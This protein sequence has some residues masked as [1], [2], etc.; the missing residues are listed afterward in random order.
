MFC[1]LVLQA[2]YQISIPFRALNNPDPALSKDRETACAHG[3]PNSR[4]QPQPW[5][6]QPRMSN[7]EEH[8]QQSGQ[9]MTFE[10]R[11]VLI[12]EAVTGKSTGS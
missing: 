9:E 5:F 11:N 8:K 1:P 2:E 3:Q 7:L 10:G 12:F 6:Q 4:N